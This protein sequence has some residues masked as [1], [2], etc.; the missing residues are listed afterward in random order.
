VWIFIRIIHTLSVCAGML[1]IEQ[2]S[3]AYDGIPPYLSNLKELKI[4][5]MAETLFLGELDGSIFA[6]LQHLIYLEMG[7]NLYN[8]SIPTE[9]MYLPN[10]EAF[11][12]YDSGLVGDIEFLPNMKKIVEVWLDENP[13]ME[14]TIPTGIGK[15]TD[16]ASFSVTRCDL[17]GQI[18]TEFGKLTDLEQVRIVAVQWGNSCRCCVIRSVSLTHVCFSLKGLVLREL[19]FWI[20]PIGIRQVTQASDLGSGRQQYH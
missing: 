18:P 11:Y 8:S 6:P 14:G 3:F 4:L 17:W 15:L 12:I 13:D 7:G 19:V 2:T 5:N 1:D 9:I 20:N 16:L 10:L